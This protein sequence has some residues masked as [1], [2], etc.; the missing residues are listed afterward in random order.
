MRIIPGFLFCITFA[1]LA[2]FFS[3]PSI[4]HDW[5]GSPLI[6][7]IIAGILLGNTIFNRASK[8]LGPGVDFTK[9]L[10]LRLGIIL[11][12]FKITFQDLLSVGLV[13]IFIGSF[14]FILT[15]FISIWIGRAVFKLE[16]SLVILI[17]AG[18][19]ICGAAAVIATESIL[20]ATP[21]KTSIAVAT[22]VIFGTLSMFLYPLLYPFLGLSHHEYGIYVGS[23]IHEVAQVVVAGESI[24]DHSAA[25]A[26]IEKM[27]RVILL[28][29]FLLIL[30]IRTN[31][32]E[33]EKN[34]NFLGLIPWFA[35]FFILV[36]IINSFKII[37]QDLTKQ[38]IDVDTILLSAAMF[39]L[40]IRTHIKS[41]KEAGIIPLK[42]G[43]LIWLFL[44]IGGYLINIIFS[45]VM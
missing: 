14:L 36:A 23:T 4:V 39:A 29:P 21:E 13:G 28:V 5:G 31:I 16:E 15:F 38:L 7:A 12:G 30:G 11:F 9:F 18:A 26:V 8:I 10:I 1:F 44:T 33:R 17:G 27:F 3:K 37:S 43:G 2:I 45:K 34:R 20:R 25:I 22:V 6:F 32:S 41:I 19:S 40:G 42:L 24:S 35:I